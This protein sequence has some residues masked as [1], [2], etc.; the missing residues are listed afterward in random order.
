[1]WRIG[2][3]VSLPRT[4]R[5]EAV[6]T[7]CCH[8]EDVRVVRVGAR[9][10]RDLPGRIVRVKFVDLLCVARPIKGTMYCSDC[11]EEK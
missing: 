2:E 7:G 5:G 11:E 6:S 10:A 9:R 8:S 3:S 4:S 1:M